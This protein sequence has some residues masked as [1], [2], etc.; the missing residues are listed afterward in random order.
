MLKK[1]LGAV[2]ILFVVVYAGFAL[3]MRSSVDP[4]SF[5]DLH[6]KYDVRIIRDAYG[7]PHIYGDRDID[8]AFGL[9]FAHAEDD[10]A[11]M[12]DVL[13]ATRGKLAT[14]KG[15]EAS[16]TDYLIQ[17]MRV[18]DVV[19]AG[20]DTRLSAEARAHAEAYAD[21]LNYFA[22][23]NR[24]LISPY[25]L[26]VT[27]K[28]VV[29][30]FT[31]K[32][33]L[34]YGFDQAVAAAADGSYGTGL[35]KS[36]ALEPTD[37]PQ[38][39]IGSQGI[40]VAPSRSADGHT[41]LLV[42]S[43]QPLTGPVAWYEARVKSN[44]GWDMAGSTFPGSPV[45]LHGYGPT[46]G[47]SNTVNKPDLVDVYKLVINPDNPNQ[48]KLDGEWRDF[49]IR[50]AE[51]EIFFLGPIRW[52][53]EE[54]IYYS[55]HGPVF[56]N[57]KGAFALRWAGM[58]EVRTLDMNIQL[59]KARTQADFEAALGMGAM[60]SINYIYADKDGNIAHYYN[61]MMPKRIEG[62][63]W[64]GLLPG[65]RSDLIWR[66][67][68]PFSKT[69]RTVNPPSGFVFNANNTPFVASVGEGQAQPGDFTPSMGI[70]TGMTNRALMIRDLFGADESITA[71]E[72]KTYKYNN[73]YHRDS[74][75]AKVLAEVLALQLLEGSEVA[76]AQKILAKWDLS[77]GK[78][79]RQAALGVLTATPFILAEMRGEPKPDVRET[80]EGVVAFI[81]KFYG[82]L[83]PEWG[84]VSKLVRG[85]FTWPISGA[86]DVLRAVY[87]DINA[88]TGKL[89]A[90]AGD[91]Y[92]MFVDWAPDGT[93]NSTS[94]HNF[95]SATLD[96]SSP[97]YADQAPLFTAEK[98]R[99]L[100]MTLEALEAEKTSDRR[101]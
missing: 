42:N 32:T 45:I 48:Y 53:F 12:Q 54:P 9:A 66:E 5:S 21:G 57:K 70:E 56:R 34:F 39:D 4:A 58:D 50:T 40:A 72:F 76:E 19:N 1:I 31:F 3:T 28:D 94:I 86:P 61:A 88:D 2:L 91:S 10:F 78:E 46:L 22:S 96:G 64:R 69:P 63:D 73:S 33:P 90:T 47:W 25:L 24:G 15:V 27:G 51:I 101:L 93:V 41:R 97:H 68:H 100:P 60:P 65:D 62:V 74:V 38:P 89:K 85:D 92:I 95:G 87:S 44:E 35:D 30:G 75:A 26:P 84:E 52:T 67:Y 83:N 99:K 37:K 55:E 59:N 81:S 29:A 98:E 20:Y 77:T 14:L 13:L 17:M 11:T 71:E 16:K 79:N 43:H 18:W 7:V 6:E 8:V 80:F 49:E 36:S 23:E 82:V